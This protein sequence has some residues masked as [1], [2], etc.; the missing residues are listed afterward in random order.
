MMGLLAGTPARWPSTLGR[1]AV[2][3]P[4]HLPV[5]TACQ[6]LLTLLSCPA[7]TA[8]PK[9][10]QKLGLKR[11]Q[12]EAAGMQYAQQSVVKLQ[13]DATFSA[14]PTEVKH[15]SPPF[16]HFASAGA[17]QSNN[18][19]GT[20]SGNIEYKVSVCDACVVLRR[21]RRDAIACEPHERTLQTLSLISI[22]FITG[23]D[24][25]NDWA[26]HAGQGLGCG[27]DAHR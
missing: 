18:S 10:V 13:S 5:V 27:D 25:G 12:P 16:E 23:A 14:A 8:P 17:I 24:Q 26:G 2:M 3:M 9:H 15:V 7:L 20:A 4:A 19:M 6:V 11:A 1:C 21:I 22:L